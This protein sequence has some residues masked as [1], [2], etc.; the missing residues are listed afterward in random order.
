MPDGIDKLSDATGLS[1]ESIDNI[2]QAVQAN[3]KTL[4]SCQGPH[5]FEEDPTDS[6]PTLKRHVCRKCGGHVSVTAAV[7]YNRGL[8][9]AREERDG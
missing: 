4:E 5:D 3:Q 7:W 1:R 2:W 9:D 8:K 6:R